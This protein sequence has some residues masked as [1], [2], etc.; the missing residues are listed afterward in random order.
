MSLKKKLVEH[1]RENGPMTVAEFMAACLYDPEDG[2]YATR[3]S[4]GGESADF[5]TAPEASQMFGELIGLWCAY[6]WDALGKPAFNLIELGPGR[7]VLMQD[8]LRATQHIEG[9]TDAASVIF[10]ETS[11][12]LREEQSSRVPVAEFAHRLED[13]PPGAMLLVANEF[14]DCMPVRQFVRSENSW[15]EKL[16]GL[17]DADQLMFGLRPPSPRPRATTNR[18]RCARSRRACQ[19]LSMRSNNACTP[20]LAARCSSTTATPLP[21]APTPC[22][23]CAATRK[24]I[25]SMRRAKPISRPMSISHTLRTLLAKLASPCM[26][27]SRKAIS[28]VRLASSSAPKRW[29][30]PI[31]LMLSACNANSNA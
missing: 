2:Y 6:E 28:C 4:I 23:L 9:F 18:V 10:V 31:P 26:A 11:E 3:P 19:A 7:G 17:D 16:V 21:K 25:R 24:S 1:I 30:A 14:L 5:I 12:P 22:R 15:H 8:A 20:I 27:R 13:A 29:R